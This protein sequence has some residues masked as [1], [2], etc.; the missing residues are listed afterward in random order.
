VEL[1]L[2]GSGSA[3]LVRNNVRRSAFRERCSQVKRDLQRI[4]LNT[5]GFLVETQARSGPDFSP[6]STLL[7]RI[8]SKAIVDLRQRRAKFKIN[9][10]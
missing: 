4:F 5:V 3:L 6:S 8:L 2:I 7:V 10:Y 9:I 1:S